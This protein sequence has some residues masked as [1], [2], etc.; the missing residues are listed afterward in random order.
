MATDDD[1]SARSTHKAHRTRTEVGPGEAAEILG[2]SRAVL[3]RL[4]RTGELQ[5]RF[6][7]PERGR[8]QWMYKLADV[9]RMKADG[10]A[11]RRPPNRRRV[12]A[13]WVKAFGP[14]PRGL[15]VIPRDGNRANTAIGN[16]A[17]VPLKKIGKPRRRRVGVRAIWTPEMLV[18]LTRDFP[19]RPTHA[20]AKDLGTTTNCVG[21]QARRMGLRKNPGHLAQLV[22]AAMS[23][24]IG[25]ERTLTD[26]K[27]YG[28]VQVKVCDRGTPAQQWR[29]KTH[30][31]WERA[32]GKPVPKGFKIIFRDGDRTNFELSNLQLIST[33]EL[34]ATTTAKFRSYPESV[35]QVIRLQA[36]LQREI[37]GVIKSRPKVARSRRGESRGH[38]T[39][40]MNDILCRDY[41]TANLDDLAR[42]LGVTMYAIRGRAV[43]LGVT[44]SL[45][46]TVAEARQRA[47][48]RLEASNQMES[49]NANDH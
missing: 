18:V 45:D 26:E 31:I 49:R 8:S 23:Y 16:L 5:A 43:K 6:A 35:Q 33:G 10:T 28:A 37:R 12:R 36:Q 24:P 44:R 22:R 39:Q 42:H 2:I 34:F 47:A 15:T 11:L 38:W 41:P 30:V 4:G 48:A 3:N 14:I 1:Q 27:N 29:P 9:Q 20:I 17:L 25:T 46:A 19:S 7:D 40:E 21:N 13:A 32:N